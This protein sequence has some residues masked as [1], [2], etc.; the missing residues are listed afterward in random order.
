[1]IYIPR[2]PFVA[3][4][5]KFDICHGFEG[6]HKQNLLQGFHA[7]TAD[8]RPLLFHQLVRDATAV[9]SGS[10]ARVFENPLFPNQV[11]KLTNKQDK[12]YQRWMEDFV[13]KRQNNR[14][15][16]QVNSYARTNTGRI[17]CMMEKLTPSYEV[18]DGFRYNENQKGAGLHLDFAPHDELPDEL[19]QIK[20]FLYDFLY[21]DSIDIRVP[22]VMRRGEQV[23]ITDPLF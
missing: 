6:E 2:F 3:R 12:G 17:L 21:N 13:L 11:F 5:I 7:F 10:Y 19:R 1:M 15:V 22:N 8:P 9:G 20:A 16:P 14:F 4:G 23:V 18:P